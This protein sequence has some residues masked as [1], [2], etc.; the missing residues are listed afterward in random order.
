MLRGRSDVRAE[1]EAIQKEAREKEKEPKITFATLFAR[2]L[3]WS[4]LIAIFLMFMQQMSGINAAMYY[5]N[6]IFKS[7]GL[8]GDQIILATCAIMLTNVLMTLASEWLVDH[9]LFGRRFLLL[10]G[11]LGMFLMS[12]GI[13]A[14]LILIV[15]L[16][17]PIFIRDILY[18]FAEHSDRM[19]EMNACPFI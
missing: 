17:I 14:S 9:P 16:I 19:L 10:T 13:V 8:I 4:T 12:I 2:E 15:S 18:T 7:T 11:M 3:R 5:S 6:D 1:I